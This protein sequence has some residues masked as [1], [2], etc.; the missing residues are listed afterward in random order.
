MISIRRACRVCSF[1]RLL[2]FRSR[3][4]LFK[5]EVD[6]LSVCMFNL[7]SGCSHEDILLF[8]LSG[9]ALM[10]PSPFYLAKLSFVK[11]LRVESVERKHEKYTRQPHL[12][13]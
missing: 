13:V 11:Y 7:F 9:F 8:V 3:S 6:W 10:I 1:S 5:M 2:L 4:A 12:E